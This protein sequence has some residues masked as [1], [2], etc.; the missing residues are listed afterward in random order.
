[1]ASCRLRI[2]SSGASSK[3]SLA[4]RKDKREAARCP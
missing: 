1:M 4:A 2:S 3:H